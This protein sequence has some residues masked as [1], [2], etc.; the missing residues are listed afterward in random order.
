MSYSLSSVKVVSAEKR[1]QN[2]R[3][4]LAQNF[5]RTNKE[6]LQNNQT[7]TNVYLDDLLISFKSRL[8]QD[9][10]TLRE[11]ENLTTIISTGWS[12]KILKFW[13]K[14]V[15]KTCLAS[16][17]L[18]DIDTRSTPVKIALDQLHNSHSHMTNDIM[19]T[20][21]KVVAE[22]GVLPRVILKNIAQLVRYSRDKSLI[23]D[24]NNGLWITI[25]SWVKSVFRSWKKPAP[26]L[27]YIPKNGIEQ[28][29]QILSAFQFYVEND[30]FDS[31]LRII[32]QS[33]GEVRRI[34]NDWMVE[35]RTLMETKQILQAVNGIAFAQLRAIS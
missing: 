13:T 12:N 24:E 35:A 29:D 4:F 20:L 32:N 22:N 18:Y 21:P 28:V 15:K 17:L 19:G 10:D 27:E 26:L 31:A 23:D 2:L 33:T 9:C 1:I 34:F 7:D 5:Q 8:A 16:K 11:I 30:D 25:R 3:Y 6:V 14:I